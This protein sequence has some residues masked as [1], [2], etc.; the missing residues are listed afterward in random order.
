MPADRPFLAHD[1]LTG[2]T[3]TWEGAAPYVFLHPSR[4]PAH[5]LHLR[6]P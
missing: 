5:L 3:Y 1:E 6:A 4:Q 2:E